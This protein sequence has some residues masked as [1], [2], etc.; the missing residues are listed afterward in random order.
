[1]ER[2]FR[3]V[4]VTDRRGGWW[5]ISLTCHRNRTGLACVAPQFW[6]SRAWEIC[7]CVGSQIE[8]SLKI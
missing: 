1:M 4:E 8:M 3:P 5:T 7:A 6:P 2:T